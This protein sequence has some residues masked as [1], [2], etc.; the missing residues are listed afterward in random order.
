MD[1]GNVL[2]LGEVIRLIGF[3]G[4]LLFV[5]VLVI[6]ANQKARKEDLSLFREQQNQLSAQHAE[7]IIILKE[8]QVQNFEVLNKFAEGIEYSAAKLSELRN[9]I[10]VRLAE[11]KSE[12]ASKVSEV[13]NNVRNNQFCPKVREASGGK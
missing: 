11:L 8:Q 10:S 9:E 13:N 6:K 4:V 12:L 2:T 5:L 3:P 7:Q 1:I